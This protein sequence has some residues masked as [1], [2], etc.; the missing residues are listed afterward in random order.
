MEESH[1]VISQ[2]RNGNGDEIPQVDVEKEMVCENV[3]NADL[4]FAENSYQ[5]TTER[6][7]K[8]D[9]NNEIA[10]MD[11]INEEN[12]EGPTEN[13]I[14]EKLPVEIL[15][16]IFNFLDA[17]FIV[18]TLTKVCVEFE[19][20]FNS[21]IYWK[22]RISKQWPKKYPIVPEENFDWREACI[23]REEQY[24]QWSKPEETCEH[25]M[26]NDNIFASVD[27]VH[28]MKEGTLLATGS[29]DRYMNLL[30]LS[31]YDPDE[32]NSK[33][34][35]IVHTDPKA[36]KGWIWSFASWDGCLA[37]GSWDTHVKTW[38]LSGG[39]APVNDFKCKSAV[40]GL[41]MEEN[42][43]YAA[44]YNSRTYILDPRSGEVTWKKVHK[45]PVLCLKAN[46]D[47]IITGSEDKT[48]VIFDRRADE[49]YKTIELEDTYAMCI[50]YSNNQ[51]WIGDKNGQIHVYDA[52]YGKFE[53]VKTF[54][55][56]HAEKVTGICYTPGA[57]FTCS[58]DSKI[59]ILEPNLDPG[60]INTLSVHNGAVARLSVQ[61]GVL[62]SA[63][64]DSSVGIWIP[65][66]NIVKTMV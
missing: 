59:K 4:L 40:L 50:S 44:G 29:R 48:V 7:L 54:D 49:V 64:S 42:Q 20:M 36:H 51:L 14:L 38:D 31:K 8:D 37:T 13:L 10:D 6:N 26:F 35:V 47:Y 63:G 34:E 55:V 39:C 25:F 9:I 28:L 53:L 61:N 45:Q 18:K 5:M 17:R 57:L 1:G 16:H 58:T 21:D 32:P 19:N 30:D 2:N 52:Q 65:K 3:E 11:H 43:I 12:M 46:P 33:K 23:E 41:H 22:T 24:R 66:A 15:M 27:G 56:G 60:V 62:A